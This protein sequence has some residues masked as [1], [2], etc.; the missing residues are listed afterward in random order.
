MDKIRYNRKIYL[1]DKPREKARNEVLAAF[2][3]PQEKEWIPAA[4][5][6]AELL[7]N[8]SSPMFQCLFTMH[9]QWT[10]LP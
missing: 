10:A 5:A 4:S 6:L 2:D 1:E 3:L 9:P 7:L 8:L